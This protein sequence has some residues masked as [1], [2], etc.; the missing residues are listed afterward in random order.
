MHHDLWTYSAVIL[1]LVVIA[2]L[3]SAKNING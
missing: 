1:F 2:K 3:F